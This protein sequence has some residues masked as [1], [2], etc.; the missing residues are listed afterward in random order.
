VPSEASVSSTSSSRRVPCFWPPLSLVAIALYLP[1]GALALILA[2]HWMAQPPSRGPI[3]ASYL[4]NAAPPRVG[5]HEAWVHPSRHRCANRSR[6]F[7]LRTLLLVNNPSD[8]WSCTC[9]VPR[10]Q[11]AL[12]PRGRSRPEVNPC[13]FSASRVHVLLFPK[14]PRSGISPL[15]VMNQ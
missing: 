13:V 11:V 5:H 1:F 2:Q 12:G 9:V 8:L 14:T 7:A 3:F 6:T 15:T 4:G 10:P